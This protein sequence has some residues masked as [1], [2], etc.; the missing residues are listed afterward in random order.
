[1]QLQTRIRLVKENGETVFYTE[2]LDV[3]KELMPPPFIAP[4]RIAIGTVLPVG[5]MNYTIKSVSLEVYEDTDNR[6]GVLLY[7]VGERYDHNM[8]VVITAAESSASTPS[9][10]SY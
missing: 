10:R 1:M 5:N 2:D 3:I 6:Y 4:F 9:P 8:V 7:H